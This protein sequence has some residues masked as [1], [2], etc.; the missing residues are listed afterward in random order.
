[1]KQDLYLVVIAGGSGTRF[2]PKST[3]SR[4]KQLLSFGG[5]TPSK[6][7]SLLAQT[8]D[9]F[10][11]IVPKNGFYIAT[12]K[13]LEKAIVDEKLNAHI[14]AEPQG[15]NT[16]PCIYWAA[17]EVAARDPKGILLV[18]PADHY[19]AQPD[20]LRETI[21]A[22]SDWARS[23][24]DLITLAIRPTRPETGYGYLKVSADSVKKGGPSKVEAFVEKPNFENA[25]KFLD[26]GN[27]YWN[28]GM[29]VWRADVIL[30][31]FD[32]HMPEMKKAWNEA[33]GS[34]EKAYPLMTATSI[35]YGVMEKA[36]NVVT[37]PLDCGWDDLGSWTSLESLADSLQIRKGSNVVNS[38][39]LLAVESE[40]N[41]VDV[42]NSFVA[43]LDVHNLI[44][45]QTP[46]ALLIANKDKA[47]DLRKIV[48]ETKKRR[49][50]LV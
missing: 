28:G 21:Q 22:A 26:A 39:D 50:D 33:G 35:D 29:F 17:K 42:S 5:S 1:M 6:S 19:I 44:V 18:M 16:A 32:Q 43:L 45:V 49:P 27:Y 30:Q 11:G 9:R 36:R 13:K 10:E 38:G 2:W 48:E 41:I 14:L 31:A 12:T 34:I 4:P 25:K 37:F 7:R 40:G 8:L 23:N 20:K 24:D 3:S 46:D 47:Q 15:R